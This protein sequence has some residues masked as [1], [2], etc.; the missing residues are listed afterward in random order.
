[1]GHVGSGHEA[2]KIKQ[3]LVVKPESEI[4]K[5]LKDDNISHTLRDSDRTMGKV[6]RK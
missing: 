6:N 4:T 2:R 1:M 3:Y 5:K